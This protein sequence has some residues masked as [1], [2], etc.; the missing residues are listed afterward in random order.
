MSKTYH[1]ITYGCDANRADSERIAGL[2]EN[3]GYKETKNKEKTN[4]LIFNTC[5][6]RQK[7]EDRVFGRNKEMKSLKEKKPDL[8]IALAGCMNHYD[9]KTLKD[10]LPYIDVFLPMK[11]LSLLPQKLGIK[12]ELF[13]QI[14][15]ASAIFKSGFFSLSDFISLFLPK[16]RSSAF[17]L[18]EQVLK[19]RRLVFSLFFVS[20]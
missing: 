10:R 19:I 16:T 5:S 6:V 7:A 9:K 13:S 14:K 15:P 17:C 11:E 3:C 2:L 4:L 1:I 20:L 12:K 18:T 8:K